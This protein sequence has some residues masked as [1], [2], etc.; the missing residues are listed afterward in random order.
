MVFSPD[1]TRLATANP[2]IRLWD[3]RN[4]NQSPVPLEISSTRGTSKSTTFF[5]LAFSPDGSRLAAGEP[6]D[7]IHLFQLG[8]AAAAYL[9]TRVW[10]NLSM[11]EWRLYI[12]DG[13]PY[14]RTC[15]ALPA[16]HDVANSKSNYR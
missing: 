16:G 1:G 15:P 4:P 7:S 14:E 2:F 9:C 6:D 8:P 13:V 12:G 11:D 5:V 10:R 3:L